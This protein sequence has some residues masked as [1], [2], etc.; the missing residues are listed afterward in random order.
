MIAWMPLAPVELPSPSKPSSE[1]ISFWL[2]A[3]APLP[4]E[5]ALAGTD[6][7]PV[8]AGLEGVVGQVEVPGVASPRGAVHPAAVDGV[9]GGDRR[10]TER[11][12]GETVVDDL[13][14][15]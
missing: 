15:R 5:A 3:L 12:V 13:D 6:D 7:D 10:S 14:R 8:D 1:S 2:S 9:V 11:P 4:S